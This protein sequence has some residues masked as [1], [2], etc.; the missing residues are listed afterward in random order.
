MGKKVAILQSNYIPWKGY[1]DLINSVDEFIL[2]DEM[3]YTKNDW[4]NRNRIKTNQGVQWLTIP[5]KQ[6]SLLQTIRETKTASDAWGSKH[7]KTL[8]LAYGRSRH[9]PDFWPVLKPL[10]LDKCEHLLSRINFE[11]IS[12]VNQILGIGTRLTW[13]SDY[14]LIG[15]RS[16]RLADLC[17]Q[18]G[19]NEYITGPSALNYMKP[20]VFPRSSIAVKVADYAGY[21]EYTQLY[22]PFEHQVSVLDLIFNEGLDARKYMKTFSESLCT[23]PFLR[24]AFQ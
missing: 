1:F 8:T 10:Y 20:E 15:D 11:F 6:E 9:F 22:P 7:A 17:K 16:E 23:E 4:R 18:V 2:Y 3:Q 12:V 21:P 14:R 13:S 5:V 19:A 24:D